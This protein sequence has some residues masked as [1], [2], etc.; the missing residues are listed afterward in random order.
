MASVTK[1]LGIVSAY[2]YAKAGGYTG[3]EEEFQ[4]IFNEFTEDAPG[5]LDR[6]DEAVDDA[7]AA[8][9]AA[10]AA[11][12][13]AQAAKTAAENAASTFTTDTTLAVSGKAA[14]AKVTGDEIT[15]LKTALTS[16]ENLTQQKLSFQWEHGGIDYSTGQTNNDGATTRSRDINYY[17]YDDIVTVYNNSS[18]LMYII[19]YNATKQYT[20]YRAVSANS[21]FTAQHNDEWKFARFDIR[22]SLENASTSYMMVKRKITRSIEELQDTL[23]NVVD[24]I[25]IPESTNLLNPAQLY[26]RGYYIEFSDGVTHKS[27]STAQITDKIDVGLANELYVITTNT[28]STSVLGILFYNGDEYVGYSTKRYTEIVNSPKYSASGVFTHIIVYT[29]DSNVGGNQICVSYNNLDQFTAY[30]LV[31]YLNPKAVKDGIT[32]LSGKVIANFGDSIFGNKRPPD[33]ISTA[34]A[35]ITGATAYNLGFGGC[36]MSQ[37]SANWDA[38]SMYQLAYAIANNDFAAQNAVDVDNVSGMPAYFKETR[39]LLESIDFSKV[40]IITISYG[41]NDFTAGVELNNDNDQYDTTTFCGALRYS[42]NLLLAAYPQLHI[43]VCTP[44]WR[45]W[46]DENNQFLYDSDTHEEG[47]QLLTAFV[48]AVQTV[49]RAYH[50][51][52]IDNYYEL[53]INQYNR[54]HWFPP[55]DGTHHNKD[56]GV[57]IA[58]HM[59]IEMF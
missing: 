58:Q 2:G 51:K 54:S 14:D 39:A 18:S 16:A 48:T 3:T 41:T 1:D 43:F 6:L 20:S 46:I 57:L 17:N 30:D 29:N 38:F 5:L 50:V 59:A 47:G 31:Y 4:A 22:C 13:A 56:G 49:S 10:V 42:L 37:H 40:D 21:S 15:G 53:G 19:F 32:S 11:N 44:T 7:E 12:T 36:R 33:D 34:L 35:K 45:F 9:A 52:S 26:K 28:E 8:E 24:D 25:T 23:E 27:S 55:T